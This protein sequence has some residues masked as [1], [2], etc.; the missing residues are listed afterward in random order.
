MTRALLELDSPC[1][2][3]QIER[4]TH[5]SRIAW[6]KVHDLFKTPFPIQFLE[7]GFQ[8]LFNWQIFQGDWVFPIQDWEASVEPG[9]ACFNLI[10][11]DLPLKT[12][13]AGRDELDGLSLW[14]GFVGDELPFSFLERGGI[15]DPK[16]ALKIG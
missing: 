11:L 8:V 9:E 13:P 1:N 10:V 15:D 6:S 16:I 14:R 2:H 5:D 3:A 7:K 12:L 4:A